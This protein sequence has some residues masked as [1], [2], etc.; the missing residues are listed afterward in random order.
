MTTDEAPH[1]STA[2]FT[3][4]DWEPLDWAPDITTGLATGHLRMTKAYAGAVEGR[5]ITQ[6]TSAY[7]QERGVGHYVAM[8]SFEGSVD[9]RRGSFNFVHAASTTG[10]DRNDEYG[11]IVAGSGTGELAGIT[12]SVAL[13]IDPDGTH[14]MAFT[15][16]L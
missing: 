7:D 8:E 13:T 12:G 15:Y 14:R 1:T 6:F 10:S 5:S 16:A 9:G 2:T 4:G 3:T 11:V